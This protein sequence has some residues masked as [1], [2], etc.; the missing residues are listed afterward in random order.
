MIGL[1][2]VGLVVGILVWMM[3]GPKG[4]PKAPKPEEPKPV[5]EPV[6]EEPKPVEEEAEGLDLEGYQRPTHQ[7]GPELLPMESAQEAPAA[8]EMAVPPA[9][10]LPPIPAEEAM[11]EELPPVEEPKPEPAPEPAKAP[12]APKASIGNEEKIARLKKAFEDGKISKEMYELN[13]KKLQ[14]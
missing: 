11:P 9:E 1:L 4:E 2:V 6:P 13:L 12:E 3:L 7:A 5:E 8:D 14:G 10:E